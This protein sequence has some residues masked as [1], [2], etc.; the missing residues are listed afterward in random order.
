MNTDYA[1]RIGTISAMN[2]VR[3]SGI[4]WCSASWDVGEEVD[5]TVVSVTQKLELFN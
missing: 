4:N 3:C 1:S 2:A 5:L